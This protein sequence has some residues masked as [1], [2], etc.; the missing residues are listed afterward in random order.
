MREI[1]YDLIVERTAE[2]CEKAA[3]RL[4][5]DVK[6]A[7]KIGKGGETSPL[8]AAILADCLKNAE[9][10]E[11]T[12]CPIC[13]DT[14]FAVFFIEMGVDARVAGGILEDAL[15]EGTAL[16]YERGFLRKSIVRDPIFNRENTGD[17]T[18]PVIH[19]TLVPGDKLRV[20]L[21]PKGGG[22]ENMSAIAMLKP[23]QGRA[24]VVDF[25]VDTV[26]RAGGNPCPPVVVGV[27]VGGTFEKCAI[28]AK[29]AL[30]REIGSRNPN[31][32]YAALETEILERINRSGIGPQGL[33][34]RN[35]ALAA[36]IEN[37]PCHIASLPVAVNLNCHAARHAVREI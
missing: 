13:Q 24:G 1:D 2:L 29:K 5:D 8:G 36:H 30:L 9:I 33:G 21:A 23:S 37:H 22:S 12:G 20:T 3:T 16:G 32:E 25:V 4:P 19:L 7:I 18:P 26:V 15:T 17:N 34:G 31:E 14:G 10:A 35:T 11:T 6:T 28:L 27:G